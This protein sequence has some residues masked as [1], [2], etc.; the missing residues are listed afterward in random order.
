MNNWKSSNKAGYWLVQFLPYDEV[1]SDNLDGLDYEIVYVSFNGKWD[2]H[3]P[4][5]TP[6]RIDK[7]FCN[8]IRPLS[9]IK[10]NSPASG[11]DKSL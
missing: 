9:E 7:V 2:V 10:V 5:M 1:F 8:F 6:M 4:G 11:E 3:R